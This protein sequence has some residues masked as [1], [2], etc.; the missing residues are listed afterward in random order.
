MG[1]PPPDGPRARSLARR[2]W[3]YG[4]TAVT[5]RRTR[6]CGKPIRR[7]RLP[8]ELCPTSYVVELAQEALRASARQPE[9]P[10]FLTACFPDP[11]HPFTPPGRYWDM[12]D[13]DSISVPTSLGSAGVT[14]ALTHLRAE[15]AAGRANT[16]GTMPFA[17]D[18][19]ES[20][21]AIALSYGMISMV[22]D[23][24]GRIL[25]TLAEVGQLDNTVVIFTSDHGDFMGDHGL[26][27]KSTLH[28]QGLVRVPFIWS[29]PGLPQ[30]GVATAALHSTLDVA[31]SVLARAGLQPYWGMQGMDRA[32]SLADP[33]AAG[34]SAVLVEEDGHE[35]GFGFDAPARRRGYVRYSAR[36]GACRSMKGATGVS[37]MTWPPTRTRW[38]TCSMTRHTR[39]SV[40]DSSSGSRV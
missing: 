10:F 18:E 17:V 15:R 13:P 12:Y 39:R 8:D 9:Q 19:R 25:Q 32:A 28:Y 2:A 37:C 23:G 30:P 20:R 33:A 29:E 14:P 11:H 3:E 1:S 24:I 16:L 35:V 4:T 21:E 27:L 22:D 36:I 34:Q 26:M 38:S 7:T 5:I 31:R 40:P 6:S